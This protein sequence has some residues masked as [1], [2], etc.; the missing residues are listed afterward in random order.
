MITLTVEHATP[1]SEFFKQGPFTG[2]SICRPRSISGPFFFFALT[3]T[4][5]AM[6]RVYDVVGLFAMALLTGLGGALI[7]DGL[8][9][10]S[11]RRADEGLAVSRRGD[12]RLRGGW[13]VGRPLERYQ[14]DHRRAGRHRP[15]RLRVVGVQKSLAA[16]LSVPAAVLVESSTPV[17]AASCG[18]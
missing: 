8:F 4:L 18:T 3:G 1:L 13:V 15:G 7:R 11:A 5:A 10:Q 2:I 16:G 9:L 6:R 12:R 17:G 14:T